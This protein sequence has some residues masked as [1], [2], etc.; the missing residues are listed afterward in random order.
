MALTTAL[1]LLGPARLPAQDTT[2]VSLDSI[3]ERLQRAE[4]AIAVLRE[5]LATQAE[6]GV[7][8][9]SRHRVELFGRVMLN[10]FS[11]SAPVNNAD[12]P[13][14]AAPAAAGDRGGA[15]G[16]IRQTSFGVSAFV[17]D[18]LGGAFD[19]ELHADFFGGQQPSG[20]G[21]HFPLLRVRTA[22]GR[23]SWERGEM[24]FGQEVPLVAG[25]NPL[26]VAS[27]GTPE[28]AAAGNLWLWLPQ[29]RGTVELGTPLR[30]GLQGAVLAPTSGDPNQAFDTGLDPA[31]RS[32]RPYLQSRLRAR[33]GEGGA[34]RAP[35]AGGG[36]IGVGVHRG[37]LR[38]DDG[39]LIDSDAIAMDARVA[40]GAVIEVRAEGYSGR[41]LR[42]LGGGGIGQGVTTDGRPVRDR[43]GWIQ[44]I[45]QVTPWLELAGGCGSA[46]PRN[47]DLPAG[48]LRNVSCATHVLAQPSGP[49]LAGL[50]YRRQRTKYAAGDRT[51]HHVNLAV[52]FEF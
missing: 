22:I 23:L 12:V 6:S 3:T 9:A 50:T 4:Q 11:N 2:L 41:A 33:W 38:L 18:V 10:A 52:G 14:F 48:R 35:A 37:W 24:L 45:A 27:F 17:E 29:L 26:S 21:R 30:L 15:G 5:Q 1:L 43:G 46:D 32:R 36:E 13:L 19:G 39:S 40:L 31:E 51:N 47:D 28:F 42:G 49:M 44:L 7:Q 20:G 34:G 16:T 8:S 25:L